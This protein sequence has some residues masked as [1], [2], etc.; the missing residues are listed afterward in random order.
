MVL[1]TVILSVLRTEQGERKLRSK[2]KTRFD[3]NRFNSIP[4]YDKLSSMNT[5]PKYTETIIYNTNDNTKVITLIL[6]IN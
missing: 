2:S 1:L 6:I 4:Y 3:D 5:D